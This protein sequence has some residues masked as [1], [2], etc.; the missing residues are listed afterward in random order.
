VGDEQLTTDQRL[1]FGRVAKLYDHARPS[2]PRALVDQVLEF[3]VLRPPAKIIEVGAGTGNATVLFADPGLGVLALEPSH[4]MAQV[5]RSNCAGYPDVEV[6]EAEF[7]CWQPPKRLPVLVCAAAWHWISPEVRYQR[8][9][10]S[11]S[12][13]GGLAAIWTFPN[14]KRCSLRQALSE[15]YRSPL[16]F[17]TPSMPAWSTS[18]REDKALHPPSGSPALGSSASGQPPVEAPGAAATSLKA[19]PTGAGDE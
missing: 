1:A 10:Q 11:L 15:A 19:A 2:Y 12:R 6:I 9:G 8:A 17:S 7:E 5:A 18:G 16:M 13:G 4:E 3:A 14:W